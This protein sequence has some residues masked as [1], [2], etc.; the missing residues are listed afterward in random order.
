MFKKAI[1]ESFQTIFFYIMTLSILS[2]IY[3]YFH[4][5]SLFPIINQG[6][7][8]LPTA[9]AITIM[10]K[11]ELNII[12]MLLALVINL[13]MFTAYLFPI[14]LYSIT[15]IKRPHIKYDFIDTT[16][17]HSVLS[18]ILCIII[19]LLPTIDTSFLSIFDHPYM[20][21]F[22]IFLHCLCFYNGYHP[23]IMQ[24]IIFPLEI[25]FIQENLYAYIHDLQ[26]SHILTHGMVSAFCSMSGTGITIAL[27]LYHYKEY[28]KG[29]LTYSFLGIN[30]TILYSIIVKNKR[31]FLPY[32]IGG[33]INASIPILLM[34]YGYLHKPIFD[35]P[36]LGIGFE[37]FLV[38][39]DYKSFFV[40]ALQVLISLLIYFPY[41]KD[42]IYEI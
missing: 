16:V 28:P 35:A 25:L 32:V 5:T 17:F 14:L 27:A 20:I 9:I 2:I 37:A 30:E 22:I 6:L 19:L 3:H 34:H 31:Y 39:L 26:I 40:I 11:L 36:Y 13:D 24:L 7:N 8:L 1:Q 15:T 42:K 18:I 33:T 41:R 10:Y 23:S 4:L 12:Y 21:I 38:N 29:T